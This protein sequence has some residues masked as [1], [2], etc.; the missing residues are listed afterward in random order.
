MRRYLHHEHV[1]PGDL[2]DWPETLDRVRALTVDEIPA[3][4]WDVVARCRLTVQ[5]GFE[6]TDDALVQLARVA[7]KHG[8]RGV[9]ESGEFEVLGRER[10]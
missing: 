6:L 5:P 1:V 10:R 4:V 8:M 7:V 2:P 3:P 9:T